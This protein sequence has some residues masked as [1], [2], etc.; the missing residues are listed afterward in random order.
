MKSHCIVYTYRRNERVEPAQAAREEEETKER[1]G[2]RRCEETKEGLGVRRCEE[3]V[4]SLCGGVDGWYPRDG[5]R[6][7]PASYHLKASQKMQISKLS[8][9]NYIT[10][11]RRQKTLFKFT[12][13]SIVYTQQD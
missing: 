3:R 7:G 11:W 4:D 9:V 10:K 1:L 12:S 6:L 8:D 5:R 2:V 13:P